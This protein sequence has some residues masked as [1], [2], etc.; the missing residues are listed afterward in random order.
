MPVEPPAYPVNL[1]LRDRPV[2]V[3]GGG[4]VA[5]SKV[6]GL[7]AAGAVVTVVAPHVDG[8]LAE[9]PVAVERRPYER[10]E[11]AAYRLAVARVFPGRI[12]RAALLW[13]DGPS[14]ME[15]PPERLDEAANRL[16]LLG[17]ANLD[18]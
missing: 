5:A 16:F 14:L 9:R 10:G 6:D 12:V 4:A 8:G 3:V 2:L 13:T 15:L 18:A 17:A 11:V 1:L 7:L